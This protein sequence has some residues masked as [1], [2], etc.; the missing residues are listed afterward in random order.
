M[1]PATSTGT[2][3]AALVRAAYRA[4]YPAAMGD[5]GTMWSEPASVAEVPRT[6]LT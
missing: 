5:G 1:R 6:T 2:R 3:T 4:V